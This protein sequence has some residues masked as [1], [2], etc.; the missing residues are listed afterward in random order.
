MTLRCVVNDNNVGVE[1][2]AVKSQPGL[3]SDVMRLSFLAPGDE[4]N[5][6]SSPDQML[7]KWFKKVIFSSML[8]VSVFLWV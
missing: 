3:Q 4:N 7:G 6:T 5:P 8:K 1:V 2:T